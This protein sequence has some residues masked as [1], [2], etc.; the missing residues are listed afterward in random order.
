MTLMAFPRALLL[1]GT[2]MRIAGGHVAATALL[3][4]ARLVAKAG[5]M[6][7]SPR[8]KAARRKGR[9]MAFRVNKLSD[10]GAAEI[11]EL[12]CAQP[13]DPATLAALNRAILDYPIV[14]IR[15]QALSPKQQAA[16][17]RQLGSWRRRIARP[18]A[19][20]PTF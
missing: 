18:I 7:L 2:G 16:F 5:P 4:C 15:D 10:A 1:R 19:S 14:A 6:P 20:I 11:L 13:L 8:R 9:T 3:R 17:S 12:D